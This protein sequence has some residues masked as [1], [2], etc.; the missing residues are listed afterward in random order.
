[1]ISK[2]EAGLTTTSEDLRVAREETKSLLD[3]MDQRLK[4][5]GS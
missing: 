4:G 3:E 5:A 1:M 2:R